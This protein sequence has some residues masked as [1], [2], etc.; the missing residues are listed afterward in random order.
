MKKKRSEDKV[1]KKKLSECKR[2]GNYG[3]LSAPETNDLIWKAA[4]ARYWRNDAR[5]TNIAKPATDMA[6]E[7]EQLHK[8]SAVGVKTSISH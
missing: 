4:R 3:R 7:E 1:L 2:S 6:T 8:V 5:L